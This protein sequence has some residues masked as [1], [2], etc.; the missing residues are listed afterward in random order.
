M[1]GDYYIKVLHADD[2]VH[3]Y[4]DICNT[5]TDHPAIIIDNHPAVLPEFHQAAVGVFILSEKS[6]K[7]PLLADA[8][9]KLVNNDLPLIPIVENVGS[10]HF[11]EIPESFSPLA[12]LNA[13]SWKQGVRPGEKA[14]TVIRQYLG[15][16]PFKKHCKVFISYCRSDGNR[17]AIDVHN[18]LHLKG[19]QVFLD[20]ESIEPGE[21]VQQSI[22]RAIREQ[23]FLLLIDSPDAVNSQWI[24]EEITRA[25]SERVT[26]RSLKLSCSQGFPL[27]R[28]IPRIDWDE[29]EKERFDKLE[30][31]IAGAIASKESFDLRAARTVKEIAELLQCEMRQTRKR[32]SLLS[33]TD[34]EI[35]TK[36]LLEYEDASLSLDRLY[37]LHKGFVSRS[38]VSGAFF[39]HN[40]LPLSQTE[41]EAV[42]WSRK[43]EPLQALALT[44]IKEAISVLISS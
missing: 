23:D 20:T 32:Q 44:E 28:D 5:F 27:L 37:R 6:L 30:R 9:K 7:D 19:Y 35:I 1:P 39:I 26:V 43:E 40:G 22:K 13:V 21:D 31:M 12:R 8:L 15:L 34:G 17:V 14:C 18:H 11:S 38:D 25:L 24:M 33:R 2:A 42:L 41:Q 3:I 4:E 16:I 10:Y 29:T 36:I